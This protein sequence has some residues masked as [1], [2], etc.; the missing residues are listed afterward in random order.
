V[1][2]YGRLFRRWLQRR[3]YLQWYD[4]WIA[5][6]C[7]PPTHDRLRTLACSVPGR[8][9]CRRTG[10]GR[11]ATPI[12]ITST[13]CDETY[14]GAP[15]RLCQSDGTWSTVTS[16][17]QGRPHSRTHHTAIERETHK[18]THT[19]THTHRLID[20]HTH[21][22]THIPTDH[23]HHLAQRMCTT[24]DVTGGT[25]AS[26]SRRGQPVRTG[27][28]DRHLGGPDRPGRVP[29][30]LGIHWHDHRAVFGARR[31]VGGGDA[32]CGGGPAV[33]AIGRVCG[34]HGLYLLARDHGRHC[35]DRHV[36]Q[37]LR[38]RARRPAPACVHEHRRVELDRRQRLRVWYSG[39][40]GR[41]RSRA[42]HILTQ[43]W[44]WLGH[45][46]V[47]TH[48]QT[49]AALGRAALPV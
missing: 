22:Y 46:G 13:A 30:Q 4:P 37:W 43:D 39:N 3:P 16:A 23:D 8:S 25:S 15:W 47:G 33:P 29:G 19:H 2:L 42:T 11:D 48:D 40:G 26:V 49:P 44:L 1:R 20:A 6:A 31:V 36:R 12:N 24:T 17:C 7:L 14:G 41:A 28:V 45:G 5:S 34:P 32:V 10:L 9:V 27:H 35:R 38:R 21:M 18:H